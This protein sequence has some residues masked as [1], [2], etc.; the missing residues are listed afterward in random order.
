MTAPFQ[1]IAQC[2]AFYRNCN[3]ARMRSINLLEQ[4]RSN[5]PQ[6]GAFDERHPARIW[7][8]IV[9]AIV[10]TECRHT[11]AM[12]QVWR[13]YD[14]ARSCAVCDIANRIGK[15]ER[16]VWNWLQKMRDDFEKEC[17]QRHLLER[18]DKEKRFD[19]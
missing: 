15:S 6:Y 2:L 19:D 13:A 10:A 3:P 17:I 12:V 14:V 4:E 5:K 1:S 16:T 7:S 11:V 18:Y 8:A 9:N